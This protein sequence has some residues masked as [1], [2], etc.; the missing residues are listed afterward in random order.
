[1]LRVN[2]VTEDQIDG[3][4]AMAMLRQSPQCIKILDESGRLRFM[5]ENGQDIMEIE[6]FDALCGQDWWDLWPEE[7]RE[8]LKNAVASARRG[9]TVSF[10]AP[11]PT[12]GGTLKHWRVRVSLVKGG[13]LDGMIIAASEDVSDKVA[14]EEA[15]KALEIDNL[16]LRRFTRFVAHDLRGPIRHHKL[17]AEIIAMSAAP[18]AADK[19]DVPV[20]ADEI[21]KSAGALLDLL[22]GLERLHAAEDDEIE[23]LEALSIDALCHR[24][25]EMTGHTRLS[26]ETECND[27]MIRANAGQMLA[28][29][30]NLFENAIKYGATDL[31]STVRV[32][33]E[34]ADENRVRIVVSDNGAGFAPDRIEDVFQPMVR[35]S[36]SQGIAGSGLGLSLV[37]RVIARHHGTV[38]RLGA[39][40]KALSGAIIEMVLPAAADDAE[41]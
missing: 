29:L 28:V 40:E 18:D 5:S 17:L 34:P 12:A 32:T 13:E 19:D 39:R 38:R 33:A 37:E 41:R 6:D 2:A 10:D 31:G 7:S 16:A 27:L 9:V 36:N 21:E 25:A 3:N 20:L 26:L 4:M 35:Q 8:T 15:R 1:M 14:T 23:S 22:A 11:C 30:A 24:A